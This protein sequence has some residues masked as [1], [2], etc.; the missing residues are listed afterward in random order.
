MES[1]FGLPSKVLTSGSCKPKTFA[2]DE[3][4]S[5]AR[6]AVNKIVLREKLGAATFGFA[7]LSKFIQQS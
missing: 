6:S 3:L 1:L 5:D 7:L 4:E 2:T